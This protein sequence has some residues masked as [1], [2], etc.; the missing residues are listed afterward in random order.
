MTGLR[1]EAGRAGSQAPWGLRGVTVARDG[2]VAP[3]DIIFGV[4]DK[5]VDSVGKLRATLDE[6]KVGDTV[7]LGVLRGGKELGLSVTLQPGA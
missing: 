3:G 4:Y 1:D 5:P 2:T 7:R 6:Y